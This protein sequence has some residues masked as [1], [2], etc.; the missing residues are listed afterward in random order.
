MVIL[1]IR[2]AN[3]EFSG[4]LN[5]DQVIQAGDEVIVYGDIKSVDAA[6][7]L[8]MQDAEE[9]SKSEQFRT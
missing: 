3:G 7:H 2:H 9:V 4:A 1:N 5:K 6:A 8:H